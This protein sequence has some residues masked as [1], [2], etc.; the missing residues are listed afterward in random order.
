MDGG[1]VQGPALILLFSRRRKYWATH[2]IAISYFCMPLQFGSGLVGQPKKLTLL[3][4]EKNA[5][6]PRTSSGRV[7]L[8]YGMWGWQMVI[9]HKIRGL[10]R[11]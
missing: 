5:W 6:Q 3:A 10:E 4:G 7:R 1:N 11:I 8:E 9:Q 2:R